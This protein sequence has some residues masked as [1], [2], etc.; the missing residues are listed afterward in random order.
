MI[1]NIS[2]IL[3][4]DKPLGLTSFKLIF[5]IKKILNLKKI[6]HCGTLDPAATGLLISVL[7]KATKLQNKFMLKDKI[8]S[9]SFLLGTT[10]DTDDLYGNIISKKHVPN[11]TVKRMQIIINN[12]FKGEIFQIPPIYSALKYHGKKFYDLARKNISFKRKERKINIKEFKILS[13]DDI[14]KIVKVRIKCSSGT[15]IRSIARDFGNYIG[16]GA[17]IKKLKREKIGNFNIED[18]LEVKNLDNVEL[19]KNKIID[20]DKIE[21][22]LKLKNL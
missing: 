7:G 18:A 11:L 3:L 16:C 21:K 5:K 22:C 4:L 19:I 13:Y 14:F 10:T 20:Y 9:S 12:I 2:G 17:T 8:Y 6:G 15:Y 1:N